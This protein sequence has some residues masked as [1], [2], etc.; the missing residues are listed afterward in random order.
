MPSYV[1][2]SISYTIYPH[3]FGPYANTSNVV[4]TSTVHLLSTPMMSNP[5]FVPTTPT[6]SVLQPIMEPNP[7]VILY[8]KFNMIE[9]IPLN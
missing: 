4:G 3:G 6:K 7:I 8:L 5:L 1:Q 2:I 9:I